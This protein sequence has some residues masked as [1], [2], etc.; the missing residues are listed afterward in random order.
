MQLRWIHSSTPVVCQ[1]LTA[2][3]T[4][5]P[6]EE[7]RLSAFECCTCG[8]RTLLLHTQQW[9]HTHLSSL[10]SPAKLP[11]LYAVLQTLCAWRAA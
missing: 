1:H 5:E 2:V 8:K 4:A 9:W 7:A 6:T 10:S 3:L 11:V